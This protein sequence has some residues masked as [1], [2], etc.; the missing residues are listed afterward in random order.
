MDVR[1]HLDLLLLSEIRA[2]G[3]TH[4]YALMAGLRKRSEGAFELAEGTVYP[5]LHR[6]ERDGL[7]S[8]DW[9]HSAPRR[10]RVY[11]LTGA[12]AAALEAKRTE[13]RVFA[14]AM[15]ALLGPVLSGAPISAVPE[16]RLAS[17]PA[18]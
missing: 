12:G 11:Q 2:A 3:P 15:Q 17:A 7:V 16:G 1:G 9:D 5:A 6:L 13:W 10:R 8:S 18:T 14:R 4:G